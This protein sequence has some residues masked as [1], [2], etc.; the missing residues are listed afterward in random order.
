MHADRSNNELRVGDLVSVPCIVR[1][2][3]GDGDT[4][5]PTLDLEPQLIGG[6]APRIRIN[7]KHVDLISR[8]V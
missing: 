8:G 6:E 2:I 7:H 1:A 5:T 4:R 3:A